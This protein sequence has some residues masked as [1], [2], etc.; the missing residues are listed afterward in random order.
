MLANLLFQREPLLIGA[1]RDGVD[2]R[3]AMNVLSHE[4]FSAR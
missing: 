3:V 4:V 1:S 2:Q